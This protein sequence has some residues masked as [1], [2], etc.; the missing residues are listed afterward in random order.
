MGDRR[1]EVDSSLNGQA[2]SALRELV[3]PMAI[4]RAGAY[5][6]GQELAAKAV[7]PLT[8][9]PGLLSQPVYDPTCGTGDLLLR[10]SNALPVLPDLNGTIETWKTLLRGRDLEPEF[11]A[12]AKRRLVLQAIARGARL[13]RGKAPNLDRV[14]PGLQEGDARFPLKEPAR[15]TL[16]MNPPF[17]LTQAAADCTWASGKVSLA[18]VLFETCLKQAAPP[19]RVTA[20]LPDV[21]RTGSRYA[22]W[23]ELVEQRLRVDRVEPY[24]RF[25]DFADV[26]V[27]ILEGVV[28]AGVGGAVSWW[29]SAESPTQVTVHEL[30]DVSVGAVVPHRDPH[31]GPWSPFV[32]VGDLPPWK[33]VNHVQ[34]LRRFS[35]TKVMPPFVAI[36]RTSSPSDG[37]RAIGTIVTGDRPVAVENHLLV[38]KPRD[39]T[40]RSCGFAVENLKDQRTREWLDRRIRCRHLTVSVLRELPIWKEAT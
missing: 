5:F 37:Q 7:G 1:G 31:I 30:F 3:R 28:S 35:G 18:A 12:V 38:L 29:P 34:S 26:D 9:K 6:T 32:A 15:F 11:I 17:G 24:G 21:L 22:R 25:D 23:R 8:R 19:S 40:V 36:R 33:K 39:G 13:L 2:S 10:W 4:W 27:F 20:I 14:F 16:V